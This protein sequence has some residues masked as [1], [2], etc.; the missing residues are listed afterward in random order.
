MA[1]KHEVDISIG[2]GASSQALALALLAS[3]ISTF[4]LNQVHPAN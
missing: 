1:T 3:S 2:Q 4:R